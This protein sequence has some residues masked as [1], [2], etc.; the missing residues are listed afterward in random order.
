[1][2]VQLSALLGLTAKARLSPVL[3]FK[4]ET[5]LVVKHI[6]TALAISNPDSQQA[7]QVMSVT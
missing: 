7:M 6:F 5:L 1:M 2:R 3:D 4:T